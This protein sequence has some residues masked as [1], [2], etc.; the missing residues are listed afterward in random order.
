MA[1]R[2]SGQHPGRRFHTTTGPSGEASLKTRPE[3]TTQCPTTRSLLAHPAPK[4]GVGLLEGDD[5]ELE[6]LDLV[7][8]VHLQMLEGDDAALH[9]AAVGRLGSL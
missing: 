1:G 6:A 7:V 3:A 8:V 2:F 5:A 4:V 9:L